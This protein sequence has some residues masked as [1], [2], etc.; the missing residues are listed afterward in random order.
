MPDESFP[1]HDKKRSY[2]RSKPIEMRGLPPA[3]RTL[4]SKVQM[5]FVACSRCSA[6]WAG[7][8]ASHKVD[9]LLSPVDEGVRWIDLTWDQPMRQLLESVLERRLDQEVYHFTISCPECRRVYL[10]LEGEEAMITFQAEIMPG[11]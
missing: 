7:Y 11:G 4:L 1:K 6:F 8:Q 5:A 2:P 9:H 10:Y 3:P